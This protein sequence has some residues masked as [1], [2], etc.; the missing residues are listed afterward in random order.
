MAA[1]RLELATAVEAAPAGAGAG[2]AAAG[3]PGGA[4]DGSSVRRLPARA[5]T[6]CLGSSA[7]GTWRKYAWPRSQKLVLQR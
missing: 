6:P 4:A 5:S 7:S 3:E 1:A 2:G